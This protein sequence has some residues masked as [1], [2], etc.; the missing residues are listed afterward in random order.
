MG[1][2]GI[3]RKEKEK[4]K[5]ERGKDIKRRDRRKLEEYEEG[6]KRGEE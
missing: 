1:R 4:E 3:K 5:K 6:K 2:I